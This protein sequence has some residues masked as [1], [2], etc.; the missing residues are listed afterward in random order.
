[1]APYGSAKDP[2][3]RNNRQI[4][5]STTAY[6]NLAGRHETKDGYEFFRSQR[7]GGGSQSATGYVFNSDFA[8]NASGAPLLDANGRLIPMF[9]PGL[10]SVD[11]YPAVLGA[12]MNT[13]TN[14]L[15]VQDHWIVNNRWSADLGARYEH[16]KAVS[17]GHIVSVD[18]HRLVPRL[19]VAFD[20]NG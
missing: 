19:A 8:T 10:S 7:Q 18:N 5:G 15:Y 14:S 3:Q 20:M 11:F 6:W 13:D 9:V 4:T 1:N 17:T 12:T 2:E 16:V